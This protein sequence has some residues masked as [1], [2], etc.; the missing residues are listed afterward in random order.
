L[1]HEDVVIVRVRLEALIA[2][3]REI[4]VGADA[5]LEVGFKLLDEERDARVAQMQRRDDDS[6]PFVPGLAWQMSFASVLRR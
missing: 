4:E 1:K 6:A 2:L 5:V 3:R